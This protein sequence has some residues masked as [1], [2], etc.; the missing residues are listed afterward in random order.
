[1]KFFRQIVRI[2]LLV[3]WSLLL[4]PIAVISF[5]G[6]SEWAR[7]RRGARWAQIWARGAA[8]I[9]GVK[10]TI[11]GEVPQ[12][13]GVLLV[14]NHLGYLDILAHASVFNIRFTPNDGIRRWFLVG[15]LVNLSC[16]VWIDRKSPRKAAS[17]AEIFRQTM[18]N[19]ISLLVYP[20]GTSSDGKHGLLPFKSTVFASVSEDVP[21]LPMVLFYREVPSGSDAAWHDDTPFAVHGLKVLGLKRVDIDLFIMPEMYAFAGE[22]RKALANRVREAMIE[23][24]YKYAKLDS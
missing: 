12:K 17:Y 14:S 16:P 3:N 21:I 9:C 2:Y 7:V 6:L 20:E 1:M 24:Y 4:M 13:R 19:G 10:V 15:S 5:I 8:W 23:E 11:H 18:D 22:D